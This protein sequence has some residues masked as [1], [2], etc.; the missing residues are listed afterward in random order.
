MVL[1]VHVKKKKQ[2]APKAK[3]RRCI[4]NAGGGDFRSESFIIIWQRPCTLLKD[5]WA[6]KDACGAHLAVQQV[7]TE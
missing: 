4:F 5:T 7:L 6:V 2:T 3:E 1:S